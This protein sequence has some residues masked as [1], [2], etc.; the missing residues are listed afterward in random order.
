MED[1]WPLRARLRAPVEVLERLEGRGAG[2]ADTHAGTGG[3]A[4]EDLR[5]E[6]RFEEALVRPLLFTRERRGL[7]EP[8]QH[9]RR[10]Q[11]REQIRQPLAGLRL[12]RAHTQSSA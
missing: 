7:L 12:R 2:V 6:Q 1:E 8:L 9:A 10:L 5:F 3:V 4:G 11:L